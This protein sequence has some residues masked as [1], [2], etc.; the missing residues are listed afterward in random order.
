[1]DQ[2]LSALTQILEDWKKPFIV[3]IMVI[4]KYEQT[5]QDVGGFDLFK[6]KWRGTRN[7]F[8]LKNEFWHVD[9]YIYKQLS[10][11]FCQS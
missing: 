6:S 3:D 10:S 9:T 7:L 8:H 4:D 5:C 1:M 11:E 2:E